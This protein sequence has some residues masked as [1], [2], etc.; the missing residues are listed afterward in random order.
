[1]KS[2]MALLIDRKNVVKGSIK[3]DNKTL[4]ES[5]EFI[6]EGKKME[7]ERKRERE[8]ERESNVFF[9]ENKGN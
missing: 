3:Y 7:G 4:A 2:L 9:F 1:M 8:R 6:I 5:M